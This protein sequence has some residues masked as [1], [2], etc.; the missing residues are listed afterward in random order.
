MTRKYDPIYVPAHVLA[1]ALGKATSR[2]DQLKRDGI[3]PAPKV[4]GQWDLIACLAAYIKH[5]ESAQKQEK[6]EGNADYWAEKTRLTKAQ[7]TKEELAIAEKEGRLV[8][9]E[10]VQKVWA[11]LIVNCKSKLLS[12]PTKLAYEVAAESNPNIVLEMLTSAVYEALQELS[13]I[14]EEE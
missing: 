12:L 5:I 9:A 6:A 3:I 13:E 4:K 14:G 10:Q 2:V 7:A 8:D 1:I 11:D